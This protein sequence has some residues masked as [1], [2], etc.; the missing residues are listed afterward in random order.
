MENTERLT[1]AAPVRK[2]ENWRIER[3]PVRDVSSGCGLGDWDGLG[4]GEIGVEFGAAI[5]V[6][7]EVGSTF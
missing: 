1:K 6:F 5:V 4:E 2:R 3:G 7:A